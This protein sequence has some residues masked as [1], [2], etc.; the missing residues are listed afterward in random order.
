MNKKVTAALAAFALAGAGIFGI[1]S[2]A[3][4][5]SQDCVPSAAVAAYDEVVVDTQASDEVVVDVAAYDE[6]VVDSVAT[7]QWYSWT[8]GPSD[9][10]A[11]P[12]DNWQADNGN[13]NGFP[14]DVGLYQRDKGQSGQSDWFYHNV[15]AEISHVVHHEA[16]THVVHHDAVTHT[17][18]HDAIPE[19]KCE[20]PTPTPTEPPVVTPTPTPTEQPPVEEPTP[21]P[22]P[23]EEPPVEEP[24]PTPTPTEPPVVTPT[25]EPT[26]TETPVVTPTPAPTKTAT[27]VPVALADTST[28]DVLAHTGSHIDFAT[29][30]AIAFGLMAAGGLIVIIMTDVRRRR[31]TK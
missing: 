12:S 5:T 22:T 9:N 8:G 6:T 28:P 14:Q 18:H 20:T 21:T 30:V 2:A 29:V 7:N 3:S 1:A 4:A 25:P 27:P 10:H 13:H 16:V 23:T 11:F 24:T 17:V 15:V 19:V 26:P 31:S